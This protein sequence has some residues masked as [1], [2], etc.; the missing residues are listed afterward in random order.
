M[1]SIEIEI[2]DED[3]ESLHKLINYPTKRFEKLI[4]DFESLK[5]VTEISDFDEIANNLAKE[6]NNQEVA[7]RLLY[8]YS[9]SDV[10]TSLFLK[11]VYNKLQEKFGNEIEEKIF[12]DRMNKLLDDESNLKIIL[13]TDN[14][15]RQ[16]ERLFLNA[17]LITDLRP[18]FSSKDEEKVIGQTIIHNFKISYE[19]SDEKR[20][21]FISLDNDD[22]HLM[23]EVI[24]RAIRKENILKDINLVNNGN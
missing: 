10:T 18:L 11:E 21:F 7:I 13:K 5:N 6:D 4:N 23:K 20:D 16:N 17:R 2:P 8:T 19:E 15:K 24:E 3:L 14:L 22:L 1:I 12:Y 9:K